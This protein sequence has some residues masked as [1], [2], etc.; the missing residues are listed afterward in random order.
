MTILTGA[1]RDIAGKMAQGTVTLVSQVT[2]P[3]HSSAG[4]VVT[5]ERH[6]IRLVDGAFV[7][8]ELDPGPIRLELSVSGAGDNFEVFEISLPEDGRHDLAD[9]I[10]LTVD[11]SPG[12]I[13]RVEAAAADANRAAQAAGLSATRAAQAEAKVVTV[14]ADGA[15]AVRA[16]LRTE[17]DGTSQARIDAQA[18]Q[19]AAEE[20]ARQAK[21]AADASRVDADRAATVVSTAAGQLR[22]EMQ[23]YVNAA[24]ASEVS[25]A[26]SAQASANSAGESLAHADRAKSH[27]DSAAQTKTQIDTTAEQVARDRDAAAASATTASGHATTAGEAR[28][29][30]EAA[31]D[32][33]VDAAG[34]AEVGASEASAARDGA[35]DA[36]GRAE[37]AAGDAEESAGSADESSTL[38]ADAAAVAVA[39]SVATMTYTGDGSPEGKVTAPPGAAYIDRVAATGGVRWIKATGTGP[40]GW[41]ILWGDT[42]DRDIRGLFPEG[43]QFTFSTIRRIGDVVYLSIHNWRPP[44]DGASR[45]NDL[46]PA[47]FQPS[48]V[49]N[50]PGVIGGNPG[51]RLLVSGPTLTAYNLRAAAEN[52]FTVSWATKD[53][54]PTSL[55]GIPA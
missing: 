18:A 12:V 39:A 23:G 52:F 40:T 4:Q 36:A 34:R 51:G 29:G 50:F 44:E 42:G 46:L 21:L 28:T 53:P 16:E 2:R 5:E 49:Y 31:R 13:G 15:E 10:D 30:A 7:S 37:S 3:A 11:W 43:H 6:V 55:P 47:G 26:G 19:A 20:S 32:G 25:A 14:V 22:M 9:L 1:F 41:R 17:I 45:H 27:A 35:V 24:T 54:W 38:S 33:A 48:A 8:P